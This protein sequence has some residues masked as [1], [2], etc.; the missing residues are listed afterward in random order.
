MTESGLVVIVV[1][2]QADFT[3]RYEG[4]LPVPGTDE[5]YLEAVLTATR[6]YVQN[7]IP[8]ICTRDYHPHTHTS[9]CSNH[10][11]KEPFD[12]ILVDSVEQTLWPAHCVQTTPGAELLIPKDLVS[13][14][15]DKGTNPLWDSYSAFQDDGGN[16]TGLQRVL[17]DFRARDLVIYGLA[18]DYCVK[19]TALHALERGYNV[20]VRIDLCRGVIPEG[21]EAAVSDMKRA[22]AVLE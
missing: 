13:H 18:T 21:T 11:G 5:R 10:P 1:D 15:I 2:V 16:D 19:M 20:R 17:K 12:R 22:G 6:A 3:Q 4:S 9:F 8:V 7:G 14:V